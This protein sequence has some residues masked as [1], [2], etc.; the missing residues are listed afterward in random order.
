MARRGEVDL[1]VVD[2]SLSSA[3]L[4]GAALDGVDF[5]RALKRDARTR[6]IPILL[7]TAHAMRGDREHLL[8]ESMADGYITKPYTP[9]ALLS[10]VGALLGAPGGPVDRAS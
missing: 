10:A 8:R 2:V 6:S 9:E 4:D 5:A 3:T 7:A 1:L